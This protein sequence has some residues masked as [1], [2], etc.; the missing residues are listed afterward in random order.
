MR[1]AVF[2]IGAVQ[3]DKA[4]AD[5]KLLEPGLRTNAHRLGPQRWATDS[6]A[7]RISAWPSPVPRCSSTVITRP[8]LTSAH[9]RPGAKQRA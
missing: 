9:F 8:M 7:W 2:N 6:S 3:V 5:I 4:V 1:N